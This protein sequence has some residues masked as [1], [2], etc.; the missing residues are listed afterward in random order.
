[1]SLKI[2]LEDQIEKLFS[3]NPELTSVKK[4]RFE[5]A[6]ASFSNFKF[7]N[8]LEFDDLI[9]GIMGEGGDEGIDL[10]YVY[11]NGI[12]VKDISHPITKDS[13]VKVK[14]F[15]IK[16]EDGFSTDGF[17]KLK[18][19]IEQIFNLEIT[20]EKLRTI[21][22]NEEILEITELIRKVFRKSRVEKAK[23]SC[24]VF[25]VTISSEMRISPKIR[26]LEEELKN[27]ILTIPYEFNYLGVQDL[28]DLTSKT[29]E[30]IEIKFDS[31]P[32]NISEKDVET[33]GFA[34]FVN[35]NDLLKSLID[36]EGN[37]KSHLTEGNVRFFLGED[38]K[39]NSSIIDTA[40]DESKSSN[41]WAMNNGL[42]I[43]GDS[44][45]SLDAK[46]YSVTNPQIVN[47]CQ[48]IHCLYI[49]Y[50]RDNKNKL[51]ENLKVF[52]KLVKTE[53]LD[54]QTDII[55]ATN[56]QNPVKSAS[57][58]AND[59]IQRNIEKY[60]KEVGIYY[61]RR[62]N[63]YKR[64]GITGNKVIGLLKMAQ[65]IHTVVNKEAILA[66]NDTTTLFDTK[67][68]Y[69]S[70]FNDKADFDLYKFSTILYQKIWTI[71]NSDIRTNDYQNEQRDLISKGGFIFLHIMSSLIFSDAEY[72]EGQ[73]TQKSKLINNIEIQAKKNEFTKR[74]SWLFDKISD[75][76]LLDKYYTI[77]KEI[78]FTA[79]EEYS[80]TL[81]KSKNS[82][83]KFRGF[84]KDYLKPQIDKYLTK[85]E[86]GQ[87]IIK[88]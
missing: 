40:L 79:A 9:D 73:V 11:C 41:F 62:D 69:N 80:I 55:S 54:I 30:Q 1:M 83:F 75:D 2:L 37:F 12:L 5:I 21:G 25:F 35:G 50:T 10:C 13:T 38:K 36:T 64:Q 26:Y 43:I 28:L 85:K 59:Y 31:Q 63:Y 71:K 53:N 51:P 7:L 81:N 70:I 34:G 27:N 57:L 45:V 24:E 17:R 18:E 44:I 65:I 33:T 82:L 14:F 56:S 68:K 52:V 48:T 72:Q 87:K 29:D 22:A 49:A 42:T 84:D 15:Q 39:I 74:K 88:D 77:S 16:K 20:I 8:G 86:E 23:F 78:F 46:G 67:T 32:L 76:A 19:G 3:D 6:T 66:V 58:K 47:G 4:N 61:E 60:L